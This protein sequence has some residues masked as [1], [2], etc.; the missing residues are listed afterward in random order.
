MNIKRMLKDK[1]II[2]AIVAV[3]IVAAMLVLQTI[4]NVGMC[5]VMLPVIGITL[6]F[7][8]AGGSS[9]L[10]TYIIIGMVH[11]VHAGRS[12]YYLDPK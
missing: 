6:P 9:V 3:A 10:A 11:S 8:S 1:Y 7:V 4:V 12:K 2:A 5:L